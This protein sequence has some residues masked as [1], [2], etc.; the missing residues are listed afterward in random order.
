M[1]MTLNQLLMLLQL[2]PRMLH[3]FVMP[4]APCTYLRSAPMMMRSLAYSNAAMS[5]ALLF[6]FAACRYGAT[7][8]SYRGQ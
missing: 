5:T 7:A 3:S 1:R 8:N 2:T 6:S 4:P